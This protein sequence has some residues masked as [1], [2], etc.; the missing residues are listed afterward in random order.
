MYGSPQQ[1]VRQTTSIRRAV[2]VWSLLLLVAILVILAIIAAPL[3]MAEGKTFLGLTIYQ[4]FAP[5]CHQLPERS[6][7]L[8][9]HKLAVC[10]RCTGIYTGF[11]AA[12]LLY[13]FLRSLRQTETPRRRY[14]ILAAIPLAVDFSI[15]YLGIWEN[16]HLSR[17]LTGAIL[18]FVVVL[19]IVPGLADLA[20]RKAQTTAKPTLDTTR[21]T[22]ENLASAPSDYSAPHRRI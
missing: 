8:V 11:A 21:F 15:G 13:P 19:Y 3:A 9:G 4:S 2:V 10:S 16:T 17:F 12:V 1:Y 7:F 22:S 5:I 14:L 20:L 18:G 6:L